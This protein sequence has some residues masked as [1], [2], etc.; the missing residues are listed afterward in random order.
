VIHTL[1]LNPAIDRTYVVR[2]LEAGSVNRASQVIDEASGKG[3][4]VLRMASALAAEAHAT[5][6]L[7]GALGAYFRELCEPGWSLDVIPITQNTR[8]NVSILL[9]DEQ[10]RLKIN[11]HG[12]ELSDAEIDSVLD[13]LDERLHAGDWLAICGSTPDGVDEQVFLKIRDLVTSRG[14]HLALDVPNLVL[15]RL[16]EIKPS[17]FKPN[18]EEFQ[19]IIGESH[20]TI[21]E[22]V[23]SAENF[24]ILANIDYV[25]VTLGAL[26]ALITHDGQS[27]YQPI[28]EPTAVH[29]IGAGDALLAGFLT[30]IT[31]GSSWRDAFTLGVAASYSLALSDPTNGFEPDAIERLAHSLRNDLAAPTQEISDTRLLA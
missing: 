4:N 31:R 22:V 14:S 5:V 28:I 7:G 29:P 11:E 13:Y 8:L 10:K 20:S 15:A 3:V 19:G 6:L 9:E 23:E 26:G 17:L 1:T 27:L 18:L 2:S 12:P 25:I 21:G 24:A 30:G 16:L